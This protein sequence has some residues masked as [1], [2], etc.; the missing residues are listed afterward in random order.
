MNENEKDSPVI[1]FNGMTCALAKMNPEDY[2]KF[3]Q[4]REQNFYNCDETFIEK[5]RHG[6]FV[7]EDDCDETNILKHNLL[8]SRYETNRFSLTLAPTLGCNFEC[9]YCYETNHSD[10]SKMTPE[11][12]DRIVGIV[13]NQIKNKGIRQ[14]FITWYG[15]EPLLA[16][17][18]IESL[19]ERLTTLCQENNVRYSANMITNGYLLSRSVIER[20]NA[21]HLKRIQITVDGPK[22]IHDMRRFLSG[23]QPTFDRIVRNI[24]ENIDIIP[25][26]S[27]RINVDLTNYSRIDEVK[28][29]FADDIYMDK[30]YVY[31]APV[32]S[33]NEQYEEN[34]CLTM[35]QFA[36]LDNQFYD[37]YESS[38]PKPR[39]NA[40]GADT[41]QSM[42]IGPDG[43]IYKCW[44]DI[45]I[46]ENRVGSIFDKAYTYSKKYYDFLL[47]DVTQDEK[48][49]E[50]DILPICMGGCPN[51][52]LTESPLRC[53]I[54][55][56]NLEQQIR[57]VVNVR[58][59]QS[60]M[61]DLVH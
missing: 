9:I 30:I 21:L 4:G 33:I 45:G 50:C 20:L 56:Y 10:H 43:A 47:Y 36:E 51:R 13:K 59:S 5:L 27:L 48:C 8:Q 54:Y 52:R 16:L 19:T 58:L 61:S 41:P 17:D 42:V 32:D 46:E 44:N 37:E 25:I 7:V 39:F 49:S 12:Q 23:K 6:R 28:E 34:K 2:E 40:C 24:K 15:G 53:S 11:V 29:L 31:I 26:V 55:K 3:Q 38:Y 57:K 1:A 18:I 14:L 35:S 60:G 22:D